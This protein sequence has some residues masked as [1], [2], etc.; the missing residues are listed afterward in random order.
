MVLA[1]GIILVAAAAFAALV[2]W[3]VTG[4]A[5][6][7]D[8]AEG[9]TAPETWQCSDFLRDAAP[10]AFFA[11]VRAAPPAHLFGRVAL[12]CLAQAEAVAHVAGHPSSG[13]R[14]RR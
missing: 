14:C 13:R 3:A 12:G 4:Q 9:Y 10:V 6:N 2:V 8:V 1:I 5:E 7:C 11:P